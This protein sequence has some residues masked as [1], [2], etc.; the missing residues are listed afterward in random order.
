MSNFIFLQREWPD[1]HDASARAEALAHPDPRTAC[2]HARRG[3]ELWVHW[4]YKFD[5][6]LRLP[7]Q[8]NLSALIHE[9]TFK[10]VK[11]ELL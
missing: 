3:L 5:A 2:F 9:P 7:Y 10:Q 8:D 1:V 4:L 6:K 11:P